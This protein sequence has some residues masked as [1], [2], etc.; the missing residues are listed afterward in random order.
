ASSFHVDR[1]RADQVLYHSRKEANR[2]RCHSPRHLSI[3]LRLSASRFWNSARGSARP[4]PRSFAGGSCCGRSVRRVSIL[5]Q[6][7]RRFVST[8]TLY[9]L[10][11]GC[12]PAAL[13]HVALRRRGISRRIFLSGSRSIALRC[14]V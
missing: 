8:W 5:F 14:C 13:L 9:C 12:R 1:F 7:R 11:T 4:L 2:F 10:S 3:R 6:R